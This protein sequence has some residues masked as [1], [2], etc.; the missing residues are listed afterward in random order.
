MIKRRQAEILIELGKSKHRKYRREAYWF[1]LE[2]PQWKEMEMITTQEV[3]RILGHSVSSCISRAISNGTLL[4]LPLRRRGPNG[5]DPRIPRILVERLRAKK[6]KT[7]YSTPDG[8]LQWEESL[9]AEVRELNKIGIN[10]T[11]V[12]YRT[13]WHKPL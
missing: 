1:E 13:G 9:C 11:S 6:I 3:A 4:A 8:L 2:F 7:K 10:G 12:Y 5:S